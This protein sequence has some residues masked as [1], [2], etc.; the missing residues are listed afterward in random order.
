[1]KSIREAVLPHV[2]KRPQAW[3]FPLFVLIL[4]PY[5]D[6]PMQISPGSFNPKVSNITNLPSQVPAMQ[7][8][9]SASPAVETFSDLNSKK[10]WAVDVSLMCFFFFSQHTLAFY[11]P[12]YLTHSLNLCNLGR[13]N[14]GRVNLGRVNLGRITF[15]ESCCI[16]VKDIVRTTE[17]S[18]F[19]SYKFIKLST[20]CELN[21][22]RRPGNIVEYISFR[23]FECF[24]FLF[25]VR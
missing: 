21:H 10:I 23:F 16:F 1:M 7:A 12:T 13:V 5:E 19:K 2:V 22:S 9:Q 11:L 3:C 18:Q 25:R 8:T 6:C 15:A 14:L 4:S 17:S 20:C 24:V